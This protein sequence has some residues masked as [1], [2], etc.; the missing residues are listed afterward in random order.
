MPE[1]PAPEPDSPGASRADVHPPMPRDKRGWHVAPAPDGRGM[2][3]QAQSGP[4][5]HRRPGFLWFVLILIAVN[6]VSV[7][8]FQPSSG[9]TRVTV[10]FSPFFLAEV[11]S[12]QVRSI[13]TKG[14]TVDGTFTTKVRY[15]SSSKTAV[16]TTLRALTPAQEQYLE[17]SVSP[18]RALL[19]GAFAEDSRGSP[20]RTSLSPDDMRDKGWSCSGAGECRQRAI[21]TARYRSPLQ[22]PARHCRIADVSHG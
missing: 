2:P 14:D 6:W 18:S 10:P 16:P 5:A 22:S 7:L 17:R 4:P 13:S 3:E 1:E 15:P 19:F 9:Q 21:D 20:R 11:Q 12:G 8:L